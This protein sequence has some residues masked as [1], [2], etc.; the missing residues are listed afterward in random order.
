M[1]DCNIDFDITESYI[2]SKSF[3]FTKELSEN[4]NSLLVILLIS[5]M[6]D[7]IHIFTTM[8]L[9]DFMQNKDIEFCTYDL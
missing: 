5:L 9:W 3:N 6:H 4:V 8:S 1:H 7:L 2:D